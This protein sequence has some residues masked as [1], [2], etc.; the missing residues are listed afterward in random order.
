MI[1]YSVWCDE[2]GDYLE[3]SSKSAANARSSAKEQGRL[4]RIG[5][6]DICNQCYVKRK[7]V[8]QDE[9]KRV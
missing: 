6:Q 2:C 5:H 1:E 7:D 3:A 8:K 4:Y 9:R